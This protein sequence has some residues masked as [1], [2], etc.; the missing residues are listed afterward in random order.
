MSRARS[1]LAVVATATLTLLPAASSVRTEPGASVGRGWLSGRGH[2]LGTHEREAAH[3]RRIVD[4]DNVETGGVNRHGASTASEPASGGRSSPRPLIGILSQPW[5]GT[6]EATGGYIAASYVKAI[7]AA[8]ARAVPIGFNESSST[9]RRKL[10]AVNGVLLPGGDSDISPGTL[11]RAAATAVIRAA[12][13][14]HGAGPGEDYF[15]VWGTCMGLQLMSVI[16]AEDD[17]V[18]G[19]FDG[20]GGSTL[21]GVERSGV[22]ASIRPS[23]R[24][25]LNR[26]RVARLRRRLTN[27]CAHV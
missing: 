18:L 21:D 6:E 7:E 4:G 11:L 9:L 19:R 23:P 22:N 15:P 5:S 16:I 8:G 12:M 13:D 24:S 25:A 17:T 1:L 14:A 2:Q 3:V 20:E 26:R 10:A 27:S